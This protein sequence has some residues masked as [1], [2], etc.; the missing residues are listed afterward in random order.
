MIQ[1]RGRRTRLQQQHPSCTYP[2]VLPLAQRPTLWTTEASRGWQGANPASIKADFKRVMSGIRL[3]GG[4][5]GLHAALCSE[6]VLSW[7]P[8]A[9]G[10]ISSLAVSAPCSP[11]IL[12]QS[13]SLLSCNFHQDQPL[14]TEH[15][16]LSS[17]THL[18]Q[19]STICW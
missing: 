16:F 8:A 9:A 5:K 6:T 2:Q 19:I 4:Q 15:L 13:L 11:R 14:Q 3:N 7:H 1:Q 17:I 12:K 18:P 10:S